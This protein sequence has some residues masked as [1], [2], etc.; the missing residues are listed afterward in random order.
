MIATTTTAIATAAVVMY[1]F[2]AKRPN[3]SI[4]TVSTPTAPRQGREDACG[5]R[6]NS[7]NYRDMT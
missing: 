2:V 1:C 5:S 4:S 3:A 7:S 6:S